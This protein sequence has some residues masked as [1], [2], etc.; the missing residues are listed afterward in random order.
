MLELGDYYMRSA[1][2]NRAERIYED[3]WE[4]LSQD[5]DPARL[6]ARAEELEVLRVLHDVSPPG[7]WHA[8]WQCIE[9]RLRRLSHGPIS[10][11]PTSTMA[12][13]SQV[14]SEMIQQPNKALSWFVP[15]EAPL[16]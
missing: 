12:T 10:S 15:K 6:K 8:P 1:R 9:T 2:A 4:I 3:V 5:D 7:F 11:S 13:V 14:P 16:T